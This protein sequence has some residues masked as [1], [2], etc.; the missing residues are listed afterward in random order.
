MPLEH[1]SHADRILSFEFNIGSPSHYEGVVS[2]DG[3]EVIG[4]FYQGGNIVP[5][6]LTH[7]DAKP[8][9]NVMKPTILSNPRQGSWIQ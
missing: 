6:N 4:S 1:L 7:T 5:L 9:A 2:R 8:D 3:T